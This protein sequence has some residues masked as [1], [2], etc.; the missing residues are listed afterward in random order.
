MQPSKVNCNS[1]S[2]CLQCNS[3]IV[4]YNWLL[5]A[6]IDFTEYMICHVKWICKKNCTWSGPK[7]IFKDTKNNIT[8]YIYIFSKLHFQL[9]DLN[10][11]TFIKHWMIPVK[12]EQLFV[13]WHADLWLTMELA[14]MGIRCH[15]GVMKKIL[16][17]ERLQVSKNY[18]PFSE[19]LSVVDRSG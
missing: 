16:H 12:K 3:L 10:R 14:V 11:T 9:R 6:A 5:M 13:G 19:W 7:S 2:C 17:V 18:Y 1:R 15:V 8:V 4:S